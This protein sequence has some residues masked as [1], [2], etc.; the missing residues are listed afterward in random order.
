LKAYTGAKKDLPPAKSKIDEIRSLAGGLLL[1]AIE[2]S[3][4]TNAVVYTIRLDDKKQV[5]EADPVSTEW[6]MFE[7]KADGSMREGL[8]FVERNTAYGSTCSPSKTKKGHWDFTL[9]ALKSV[10]M[11]ISFDDGVPRCMITRGGAAYRMQRVYLSLVSTWT[12]PGVEFMDM[13]Y[14]DESGKEIMERVCS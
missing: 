1:F 6:I 9:S 12:G 2:R 8:N 3:N 11:D 5:V 4:N 14:A 10:P 13:F 7:T